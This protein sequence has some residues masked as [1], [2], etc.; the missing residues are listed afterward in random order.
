MEAAAVAVEPS[1]VEVQSS[2][3]W[4]VGWL[5]PWRCRVILVLL[6]GYGFYGHLQYLRHDCPIDLS[7]DEAHYW[8]WSRRLDLSYYSKGPLVALLIRASCAVFGDVMWAVRLPAL[9]LGVGTSLL[10][11]ALTKRLFGSDRLAL[12]AV[13]L[14]HIVPMFIAG[15]VLMTIDPPFY[16]CWALATFLLAL[17]LFD[18]SPEKA[19]GASTGGAVHARLVL[20]V[21]IGIVVGTGFLAKYA[22]L[23]WLPIALLVLW[24]DGPRGRR[25][26]R[27]WG[28]WMTATVVAL[29]FTIP[30][31]VW[32][33]RHH[34]V[35][36]R[37]VGKQTGA[38]GGGTASLLMAPLRVIEFLAGQAAVI[39]PPLVV[40]MIAGALYAR[41]RRREEPGG[42][43]ARRLSFLVWIGLPFLILATLT[44]LRAK[45]QLNWPAPAYFTLMILVAYFLSTRLR[46]RA[47]WRPWRKWFYPA[48]AFGLITMPIA[49]DMSLVYPALQWFNRRIG[50]RIGL[51]DVGVR[52]LDFTAK[53]RGWEELGAAVSE[54]AE[55]LGPGTFI[56]SEDYQTTAELAFYA[57]GQPGTYYLGSYL[58]ADTK[59]QSQYDVWPDRSLDPKENPSLL[60]KNAVFVGWFKPDLWD[61][62]ESVEEL[63]LLDIERQGIK[64][65]K[66]RVY[67][68]YNFRGMTRPARRQQY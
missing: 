23:L 49:H 40:M 53:L 48:V 39:G 15:S 2:P 60:G 22:M 38:A 41:S 28:G 33:A 27:E 17:V 25:E 5:T 4:R 1:P 61:A 65:R 42:A 36:F 47:T 29:L 16:F 44:N 11:Y 30:V 54:Q 66:F 13:L 63:P 20:W 56:V 26:L 21:L 37:H 68:C 12:G 58:Q 57:K 3:A 18:R 51:S 59:R 62:F 43:E 8:D 34:W 24:I 19:V 45:G 46:D 14:N 9:V 6:V 7:G 64:I 55:R 67:R 52:Q 10:T 31:V 32:N 35:S 50:V